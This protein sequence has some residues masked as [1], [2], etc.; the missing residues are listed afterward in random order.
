MVLKPLQGLGMGDHAHPTLRGLS[1]ASGRQSSHHALGAASHCQHPGELDK[2][3]T[4]VVEMTSSRMLQDHVQVYRAPIPWFLSPHGNSKSGSVTVLRRRKQKFREDPSTTP[5][6]LRLRS[7]QEDAILLRFWF[8]E[9]LLGHIWIILGKWFLSVSVEAQRR[10]LSRT[11]MASQG[12]C[13]SQS[14]ECFLLRTKCCASTICSSLQ[15]SILAEVPRSPISRSADSSDTEGA[16]DPTLLPREVLAK[17][18][19]T[20]TLHTATPSSQT[21]SES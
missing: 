15:V 10:F 12:W 21:L 17:S 1:G 20:L 7:S 4:S 19:A 11:A 16:R 18:P 6:R 8:R 14:H 5:K 3:G 2:Y 13:G 9:C